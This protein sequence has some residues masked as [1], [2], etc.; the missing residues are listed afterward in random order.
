MSRIQSAKRSFVTRNVNL[1]DAHSLSNQPPEVGDL[2]LAR[3]DKIR[4]H[5]RL[6][7]TQ[8]RRVYL[9]PEDEILL[10]AGARYA[11]DQFHAKAPHK[12]G[13]AHLVAAGGIAAQVVSKSTQV[14]PATEITL[15]GTVVDK[16]GQKLN[17]SRYKTLRSAYLHPNAGNMPVLLVLGSDMNSGKTSLACSAIH[18]FKQQGLK[19]AAAKLT[20]TG[21]GPDYW[22]MLDSGA[23]QVIDFVDGGYPSTVGLS[24]SKLL[25]MLRLFKADAKQRAAD[26]LVV[27]IADGVLQPENQL[28]LSNAA[29]LREVTGALV[30]ADSATAAVFCCERLLQTGLP[31]YGLG[32]LFTRAGLVIEEVNNQLGLP[33]FRL[34]DLHKEAAAGYL[35]NRLLAEQNNDA[36]RAL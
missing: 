18:G 34:E 8:G 36:L 19:V 12:L 7:N 28:L 10:I 16:Q 20:G 13:P 17:L 14:K 24:A 15:I 32:G 21:A 27:E 4:Q 9:Y 2:V 3:V 30:A 29:F 31:V 1:D 6:E 33:V 35:L 5:T 11:T 25:D 22:K 26:L 23:T